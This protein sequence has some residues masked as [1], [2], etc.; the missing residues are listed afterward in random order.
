MLL[1]KE[2]WGMSFEEHRAYGM[3]IPRRLHVRIDIKQQKFIMIQEINICETTWYEIVGLSKLT[4]MLHKVDFKRGCRFIPHG[5]KAG[6]NYE[7]QPS[8]WNQMFN[9]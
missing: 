9:C 4:Y 7:L 3:D 6:I 1:R 5:K 2:F 8:R